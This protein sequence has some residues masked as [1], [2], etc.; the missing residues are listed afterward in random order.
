MA[1]LFQ[2]LGIGPRKYTER[3]RETSTNSGSGSAGN[4]AREASAQSVGNTA[5][6]DGGQGM[7][8][9]IFRLNDAAEPAQETPVEEAAPTEAVAPAE[10][11]AE[12]TAPA[13]A[14]TE[15][16]A[17]TVGT[18]ETATTE[19]AAGE[20]A[21]T[22]EVAAEETTPAEEVAATEPEAA[23][24]VT[25]EQTAETADEMS[26]AEPTTEEK[27]PAEESAEQTTEPTTEETT[28]AEETTAEE[29]AAEDTAP[30][31]ETAPEAVVPAEEVTETTPEA[32]APAEETAAQE[33]QPDVQPVADASASAELVRC[34]S[35]IEE[36]LARLES[37]FEGKI[38][39]TDYED[40]VV[41]R[42]HKELQQYKQ[43]MY[44]KIMRPLFSE[45]IDLRNSI[46]KDTQGKAD[47][48]M[49]PVSHF[50]GFLDELEYALES[51][52]VETYRDKK[53]DLFDPKTMHII[54][55]IPTTEQAWDKKVA[56][57]LTDGYRYEDKI[58]V[59]E[60][61]DVYVYQE[62]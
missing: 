14:A 28:T 5:P 10:A 30:A 17:E 41:D 9:E 58:L 54:H 35:Q 31:E 29:A 23:E 16:P 50:R 22:G 62:P 51:C 15:E 56:E 45:V 47:D 27:A 32:A 40:K 21:P 8:E 43:D 26:T 44:L 39:H 33:E 52:N 7:D 1:N 38:A 34:L 49:I 20:A 61:V 53:G 46:A 4:T 24:A 6:M 18:T 36:R 2:R 60:K 48:E 12:E 13:E 25:E 3:Q 59:A 11:A 19:A 57:V 42:M 37:L 55:K